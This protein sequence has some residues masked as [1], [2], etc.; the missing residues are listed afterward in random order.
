MPRAWLQYLGAGGECSSH[1]PHGQKEEKNVS[2]CAYECVP[3]LAC[4]QHACELRRAINTADE[5]E[6]YQLLLF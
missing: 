6:L 2:V 3:V 1:K 4:V 5:M